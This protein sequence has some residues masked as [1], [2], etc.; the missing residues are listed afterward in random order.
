MPESLLYE[1]LK[2]SPIFSVLDPYMFQLV[3]K[4]LKFR[5]LQPGDVLFT[6]GEHGD[7]M[8]FVLVGTLSVL[9]NTPEGKLVPVSQIGAGDSIGEMAL[10][11]SLSRSA[12]IR[13]E[14]LTAIVSLSKQ[15]FETIINDYPRIGVEIL[16]GIATILSIKLRRTSEQLSQSTP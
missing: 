9:K 15:D 7:S 8:A 3:E 10:I 1:H 12:T 6:E 11:D 2:I 5:Q 16:R 14:Q 13:A 4:R